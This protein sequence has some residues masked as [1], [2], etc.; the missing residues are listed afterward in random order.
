MR[1]ENPM[2]IYD[3]LE[4]MQYIIHWHQHET[5]FVIL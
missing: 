3:V 2:M 4:E 5:K 1:E